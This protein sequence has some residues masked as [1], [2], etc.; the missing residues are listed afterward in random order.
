L[1][2]YRASVS[3]SND[4]EAIIGAL[5]SMLVAGKIKEQESKSSACIFFYAYN[6]E[7]STK[8]QVARII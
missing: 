3:D 4:K 1:L 8:E 5:E 6:S 2:I 7:N